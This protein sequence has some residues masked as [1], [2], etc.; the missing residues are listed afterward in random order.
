M[1]FT[2][3][4][5]D[6]TLSKVK[7]HDRQTK[8]GYKPYFH[9][10]QFTIPQYNFRIGYFI[11]N[12]WDVSFGIDHMKYVMQSEQDVNM[13]GYIAENDNQ[14]NGNYKGQQFHISPDFLQFEHTDGLNYANIELR[15]NQPLLGKKKIKLSGIFGGGVGIL[16]PRTNTSLMNKARYDEFHLSGFGVSGVVAGRVLFYNTFFIQSELKG[17]YINMPSIRTTMVARDKASQSFF[18]GQYNIVFG[19]QLNLKKK[20]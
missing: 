20:K 18:F 6:F 7:A 1:H 19:C 16:L 17:G 15:N 9:P 11:K 4:D 13:S 14:Y 8:F 3:E 5:Y 10:G 12:N 2:G